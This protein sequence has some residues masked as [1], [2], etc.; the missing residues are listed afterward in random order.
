V[1]GTYENGNET[2]DSR[3]CWEILEL[4]D[5]QLLEKDSGLIMHKVI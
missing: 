5:W 3:K 4:S 2:S 1:E